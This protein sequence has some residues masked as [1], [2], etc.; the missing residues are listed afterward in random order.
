MT[1]L[2][3]AALPACSC[4][5]GAVG[6]SCKSP[7]D[8]NVGLAC[9][10]NGECEPPGWDGGG[11]GGGSC[12]NLACLQVNCGR[13]GGDTTVTGHVYDPSGNLPLYNAIVYVPNGPVEPFPGGLTCDRC[14][15]FT[16]GSPLTTTLTGPDGA[17][18]L[19]NVPAG[20]SIP[21]VMQI[22]KW[23]R[24]VTLPN[25]P[26][27]A[28]TA[29]TDVNQQR[30]P[31][32][33][34]EGD[35]PQMAIATGLVDPI[36]CLLLKLGVDPAEFTP[37]AAPGRIHMYVQNGVQTS[38]AAPP[39]S[40]LWLDAG[41]LQNYDIVLLPCEGA[42]NR[43]PDAGTENIVNYTATGGR[44]FATHYSY[45]WTAFAPQPFPSA[46]QWVPNYNTVTYPPD[47]FAVSVDQS[48]PKGV[49][50]YEWLGNVGAL[51]GGRL[52]VS[53]PRHDVW[54]VN[55]D[56]G[57]FRWLYGINPNLGGGTQAVEHL[58]FNMPVNPPDLP[59]GGPGAQCGRVV[60][61]DFHV[62]TNALTDAGIFPASCV[63]GALTAQ[64]KALVFMLFDVSS[65]IQSDAL[66]PSVCGTAGRAC[67]TASPCCSGLV[68]ENAS[69]NPCQPGESCTCEPTVY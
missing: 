60:F 9:Q 27:C 52:D 51:T 4:S 22:G 16:T 35:L 38:P 68:C 45:V 64:E 62:T 14:G 39:A 34:L 29:L 56:A 24:Q 47:P 66:A 54:A 3:V 30:L 10:S 15:V 55:P 53:Q 20:K 36:E 6:S 32:S 61:S 2:L 26:A 46:A 41:A 63:G 33:H 37:P 40:Q 69:F 44:L 5:S 43:K 65:C 50:F 11:L 18:S 23:R 17:F 48:F 42:E 12:V 19:P 25:V 8:C 49:A 31:R 7:L 57:T 58:T 67:S 21:L 13:D 1:A 59:D 28:Q